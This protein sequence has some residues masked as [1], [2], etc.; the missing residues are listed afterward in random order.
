MTNAYL[1]YTRTFT[2]HFIHCDCARVSDTRARGTIE[3]QVARRASSL[4]IS[5]GAERASHRARRIWCPPPLTMN[6]SD[7]RGAS[8]SVPQG[9]VRGESTC[10]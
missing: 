2:R 6:A 3:A 5:S 1:V 9:D 10:T 7:A 4:M 8:A